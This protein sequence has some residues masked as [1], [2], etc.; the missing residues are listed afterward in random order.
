MNVLSGSSAGKIS[1]NTVSAMVG[2][3]S[4]QLPG[5]GRRGSGE[6]GL[7]RTVESLRGG[8]HVVPLR[9]D[10][11]HGTGLAPPLPPPLLSVE[12]DA[13]PLAVERRLA[14]GRR[15]HADR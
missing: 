5:R 8:G 3:I 2:D 11:D 1:A 15:A 12:F 9:R 10:V 13:Q 4:A 14:D 6:H 7:R